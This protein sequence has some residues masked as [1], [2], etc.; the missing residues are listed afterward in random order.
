MGSRH[1][2]T[3][4][5]DLKLFFPLSFQALAPSRV[6]L[7]FLRPPNRG[8]TRG[9]DAPAAFARC[10]AP[11]AMRWICIRCASV[12]KLRGVPA[13]A[14]HVDGFR[15]EIRK[16]A[17]MGPA[18]FFTWFDRSPGAPGAAI[19][20]TWDFALHI[21]RP[22]AGRVAEPEKKTVLE[23]GYGGGRLLAAAARAFDRAIGVDVHDC[24]DVVR[25]DLAQRGVTNVELHCGDGRSLPIEDQRVDV[26]YSFI[27][28]QHVEH[29]EIHRALLRETCR[30]LKPGGWAVLYHARMSRFSAHRASRWRLALDVLLEHTVHFGRYREFPANINDINLRLSLPRARRE[31]RLAGLRPVDTF[32][33][34]RRVPDGFTRFGEQFGLVLQKRL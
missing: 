18:E 34:R 8:R 27:V 10:S 30:V 32:V 9:E 19:R 31:A 14:T 22:L 1:L 7:S 20:G 3:I 28:L 2:S 26:V 23:I 15:A 16:A 5:A 12:D 4:D 33:S 24:G 29:L 6:Q 25:D 13:Y 17:A 11:D 21:A